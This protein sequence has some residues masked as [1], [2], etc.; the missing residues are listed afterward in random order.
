[1]SEERMKE[2]EALIRK[3]GDEDLVN[4][5][6][7]LDDIEAGVETEPLTLET[8]VGET[9]EVIEEAPVSPEEVPAEIQPPGEAPV[10]SSLKIKYRDSEFTLP[11]EDNFLGRKDLDGLKKATAH[12]EAHIRFLEE[13][14]AKARKRIAELE[15]ASQTKPEAPLP[16]KVESEVLNAE[17]APKVTK[18]PTRPAK[19]GLSGDPAYWTPEE[20]Q[21]MKDYGTAQDQYE[22]DMDSYYDYLENKTVSDPRLDKFDSIVEKQK[23]EA[24]QKQAQLDDDLYWNEIEEF[25]ITHPEFKKCKVPIKQLHKDVDLWKTRLANTAGYSLPL[26]PSEAEVQSF[27]AT[28]QKLAK[29]FEN[30]DETLINMGVAQPEGIQEY[31]SLA[32]LEQ[33]KSELIEQQILAPKA[34]LENAWVQTN[35]SSGSLEQGIDQLEVEAR[36]RGANSILNVMENQQANNA[37][38]IPNSANQQGPVGGDDGLGGM[39]KAQI[40]DIL[41]TSPTDLLANPERKMLFDKI[42][43]LGQF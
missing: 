24:A 39:T 13:Q 2:A 1:M 25:R 38:T 17:E 34:N 22:T 27:D 9:P 43:A 14:D 37:A 28:K 8:P 6:K 32:N 42:V 19:P 29:D 16:Q 31:Y 10:D 15:A 5:L 35:H 12:K 11:D 41:A 20:E 36:K 7:M 3:G 33:K 18:R 23:E 4:G 40:N 21:Q 26:S 30:G